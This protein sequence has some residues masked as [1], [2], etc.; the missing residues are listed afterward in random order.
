MKVPDVASAHTAASGSPPRNSSGASTVEAGG[1]RTLICSAGVGD[2]KPSVTTAGSVPG[3][4]STRPGSEGSPAT[5]GST[6]HDVAGMAP[7]TDAWSEATPN[8][9]RT[10]ATSCPDTV[11]RTEV[12][13][14]VVDVKLR[15]EAAGMLASAR[16]ANIGGGPRRTRMSP[17][18]ET[19]DPSLPAP[20]VITTSW[21]RPASAP[22][23]KV[24]VPG[25]APREPRAD[26]HP[27]G[28]GT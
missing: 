6:I 27:P 8:V 5:A 7:V 22:P 23:G 4:V 28:S 26:P 15:V 11:K 21:V 1:T 25:G 12:G 17:P 20:A 24:S 10:A 18:S 16:P 13:P 14:E 3:F 2:K 19:R 9:R